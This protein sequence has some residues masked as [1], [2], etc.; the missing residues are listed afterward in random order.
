MKREKPE[1]LSVPDCPNEVLSGNFTTDQMSDGRTIRI[2]YVVDDA[3]RE[4]VC[5]EVAFSFPARRVVQ[6]LERLVA[7]RGKPKSIRFDNGTEFVRR[8]VR[9][10]ASARGIE[11]KYFQPGNSQQNAYVE[12]FNRTVRQEYLG[13]NEFVALGNA[14][15]L[16]TE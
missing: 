2:L 15:H 1:K 8:E 12:R 4:C 11:L 6:A 14:Q 13:M 10:W 9:E 3:M 5:I 16:V 7:W